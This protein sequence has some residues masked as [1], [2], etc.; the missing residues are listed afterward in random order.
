MGKERKGRRNSYEFSKNTKG[1]VKER[2]GGLCEHC[3]KAKAKQ[4]HHRIS[5]FEAIIMAMD[6]K[7]I[8]SAE[9]ALHVC[10]RCHK[11]LDD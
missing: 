5:I 9:N 2:S 7:F 10:P 11:K 4:I 6:S 8:K 3:K 1:K